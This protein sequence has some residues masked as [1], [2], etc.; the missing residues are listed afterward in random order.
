MINVKRDAG[1]GYWLATAARTILTGNECALPTRDPIL[2]PTPP[3]RAAPLSP[4]RWLWIL[5]SAFLLLAAGSV[6]YLVLYSAPATE[7]E[8]LEYWGAHLTA[9]ADDREAGIEHFATDF[10]SDARTL[11]RYP[12]VIYLLSERSGPPFP[13]D[14]ARGPVAHLE[15]LLGT[16]VAEHRHRSASVYDRS[17]EPVV[18]A[19]ASTAGEG[20]SDP[21]L[22]LVREAIAAGAELLDVVAEPVP[23]VLAAAPVRGEGGR[24][25][26]GVLLAT[27]AEAFLF[28]LLLQ[29]PAPTRTG[30]A[31]LVTR[32]GQELVFLSPLR[33]ADYPPGG[34]RLP[35]DTTA[36][37]AL[38]AVRGV[39]AVRTYTD[40]QGD[41]IL[42]ATR[43][44]DGTDWGL[45]V[46]VDEEEALSAYRLELL[47]VTAGIIG[48]LL[49]ALGVAFGL[50]RWQQVRY[51]SALLREQARFAAL[52]DHASDP[53]LFVSEDL[54][55]VDANRRA[56]EFYGYA[57]EELVGL[58][59]TVLR[60]EPL[61]H[62]TEAHHDEV[63]TEE[64]VLV[65]T[66]HQLAS[67]ERVPVEIST[68]AAELDG[69]PVFISIVR[70]IRER[71]EAEETL[72]K[73]EER[74]RT[75]V[76]NSPDT[77]ARFGPD[78]RCLYVSPSPKGV[79]PFTVAEP[80]GRRHEELG[81]PE[82]TAE[83]L[84]RALRAV[85]ET[86]A[87]QEL[88]IS[89]EGPDRDRFFDW[90]FVPE[91]DVDGRVT[92]AVALIR[93]TT[94][95][96]ALEIQL[97]QSQKMEAVGRL[98][99]GVA[100]DFNNVLTSIQGHAAFALQELEEGDPLRDDL[101]EIA[102]SA[103]RAAALTRQLLAFSRRQI[104]KPRIVDVGRIVTNMER[105]IRR[106]IGEHIELDVAVRTDTSTIEADPSQLE[107]VLMNLVVNARDAM[108]RGGRLAIEVERGLPEEASEDEDPLV[109]LLVS[110]T[111]Q[112]M[113]PD[114][115]DHIFE[116]FFT[117]K[118]PG[119]GTGLGLSTV[120]GIVEQ[121]GGRIRVE[122]EPGEG[123]RFVLCFPAADGATA[124]GEAATGVSDLP[125]ANGELILLVEDEDG[126]RALAR[127]ILERQGYRV[128]EAA[129]GAEA[130]EAADGVDQ[131]VDLL[132]T[133]MVM[134]GL[135]GRE[136][137]H[138]MLARQPD[139]RVLLMSGYAEDLVARRHLL[140]PG[141]AFLEKPFSPEELAGRVARLLAD[142]EQSPAS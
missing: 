36:T 21:E 105:M 116:P 37:A 123:T 1:T 3:N 97:R 26:G 103:E 129:T 71:K 126:V 95:Q 68:R 53:I 122:S 139:C 27:A 12:T 113:E 81:L 84:D 119:K 96:R 61:R 43:R 76:E 94:E 73:T 63:E 91:R 115:V 70:D 101:V 99:G 50:W 58:P 18:R 66:E 132:L 32:R 89:L 140:D 45:V 85:L 49:G 34:L 75:I 77:I 106:L 23:R 2:M 111:G 109:W 137:A 33:K 74:Y 9:M 80:V 38:A 55:I 67:G 31:L 46:K 15:E 118:D 57:R 7:A 124:I 51:T 64:N 14:S 108:P 25:I 48:L 127:R 20:G 131:P 8:S 142:R 22:V 42:A 62:D 60:P 93:E 100:H 92:T 35:S 117:T 86:G 125:P 98:A 17:G 78:L 88:E 79:S 138:Q 47:R 65:E 120:Y 40:Y 83:V 41:G 59:A 44:I 24:V 10:R 11:A 69:Q 104:M 39:E 87:Q 82:A 141:M 133:D 30:E 54:R 135:D 29:Q 5:G 4:S 136:L 6:M 52:L 16:F 114:T 13:F 102:R 28:P 56:E 19:P 107:Q 112:G 121:S 90:R 130:L 110:D 128:V 134:P 72:R